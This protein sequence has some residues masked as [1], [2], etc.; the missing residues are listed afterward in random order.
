MKKIALILAGTMILA[1]LTSCGGS[2]AKTSIIDLDKLDDYF[3]VESYK[4]ETDVKEK[5]IEHMDNAHAI[6]T[7]VLKRN[8]EEMKI[9]PSDVEYAELEGST[10]NTSYYV[11]RGDCTATVK[12]M[13]KIEPGKKETLVMTVGVI[14]PASSWRSDEENAALRQKH[15]DALLNNSL[16]DKITLDISWEENIED[17][18]KALN[19]LKEMLDED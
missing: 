8:K 11:F 12:K 3:T 1:A 16:L 5:G 19:A 4:I 7:L 14:D 15:Y 17:S 2:S 18:I 6:V 13:L 10:P 9:K